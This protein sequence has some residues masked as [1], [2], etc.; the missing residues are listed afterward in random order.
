VSWAA[1]ASTIAG[2]VVEVALTSQLPDVPGEAPGVLEITSRSA[3][4]PAAGNV[5]VRYVPAA[6]ALVMSVVPLSPAR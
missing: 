3:R 5:A 6:T 1:Q 4:T 2:D